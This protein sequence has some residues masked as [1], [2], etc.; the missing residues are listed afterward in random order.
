MLSIPLGFCVCSWH[1][2]NSSSSVINAV[3][4]LGGKLQILHN[5]E[6]VIS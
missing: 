5:S 1:V 2:A 3:A 6:K 4:T